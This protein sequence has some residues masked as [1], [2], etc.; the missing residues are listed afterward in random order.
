LEGCLG[1]DNLEALVCFDMDL[2][3]EWRVCQSRLW[4][5]AGRRIG[6]NDFH[7]LGPPRIYLVELV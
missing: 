2:E 7:V 6:N 4:L 5:C 3:S 1:T